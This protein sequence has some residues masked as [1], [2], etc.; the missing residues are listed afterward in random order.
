MIQSIL[1]DLHNREKF[2]E[3]MNR[4]PYLVFQRLAEL[5]SVHWIAP[6]NM[7]YVVDYE[8]SRKVLLDSRNFV[9]GAPGTLIYDT[10][11]RH[12][13]TVDGPDQVRYRSAF[14]AA[15]SSAKIKQDLVPLIENQVASLIDGFKNDGDVEL[16]TA[17]ASRLPVQIILDVFGL[18][19]S[20]EANFREWYDHF[21]AALANF[22]GDASIRR[23]A[24]KCV[25]EFHQLMQE[26]IDQVRTS[27]NPSLLSTV[28]NQQSENPLTDE[29][30]RRNALIIMFGGIST[31]EA[32]ILNTIFAI[33][34]HRAIQQDLIEDWTLLPS[35]IE[36]S[37]RWVSPVQSATRHVAADVELGGK[38]LKAGDTVNCMLGAANRSEGLF[39]SPSEFKPAR[40]NT[41][42]HLGFAT[43]PHVCLGNNLARM[44]ARIGIEALFKRLPGLRLNADHDVKVRGYEF[45]Q[46]KELWLEWDS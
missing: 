45:R 41:K 31:V 13:L 22:E 44:E 33:L 18:P 14:R 1:S 35:V 43:G 3:Q 11:G 34:S 40:S 29:E 25:G 10:F 8:T 5:G 23:S 37:I 36:E 4:D 28:V 30:I 2:S 7:W 6:F 26:Q 15:F 39:E 9:T 46:P 32:L 20:L 42:R 24:E 16:R 21:E 38:L 19:L 17:F 12:M 27:P